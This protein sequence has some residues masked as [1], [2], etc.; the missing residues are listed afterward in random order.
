MSTT[1]QRPTY[2]C[3]ECNR[4]QPAGELVEDTYCSVACHDRHEGRGVLRAVYTNHCFCATCFRTIKEVEPPTEAAKRKIRGA[5]STQALVG[6][7]YKTPNTTMAVDDFSNTDDPY[8]RLERERWSC[9]CGAVDPNDPLAFVRRGEPTAE[10]RERLLSVLA[11]CIRTGCVSASVDLDALR[12]AYTTATR[13]NAPPTD[14][15]VLA[16]LV[17]STIDEA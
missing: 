12:T 4:P 6:F 5:E 17:G 14:D 15:D 2:S 1:P 9:T 16:L 10:L 3:A 7:Q 8:T 13:S 11:S